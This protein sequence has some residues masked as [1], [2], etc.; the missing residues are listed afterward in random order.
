MITH[1]LI[2]IRIYKDR[3]RSPSSSPI[4]SP[5][6]GHDPFLLESLHPRPEDEDPP[7][8]PFH[9]LHP[10]PQKSDPVLLLRV[11][12]RGFQLPNLSSCARH[13][14]LCKNTHDRLVHLLAGRVHQ[15]SIPE[16]DGMSNSSHQF[17]GI[18]LI[19]VGRP[20]W[21]VALSWTPSY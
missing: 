11:Q 18:V 12:F 17:E 3:P 1:R 8:V 21:S 13:L 10:L 5:R 7:R 15:R 20:I 19:S 9:E 4:P 2:V 6:S 16:F 14:L